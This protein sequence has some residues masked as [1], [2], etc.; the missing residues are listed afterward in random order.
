MKQRR[1]FGQASDRV[2]YPWMGPQNGKPG[3]DCAVL[4]CSGKLNLAS[5]CEACA[6]RAFPPTARRL[7]GPVWFETVEDL[8]R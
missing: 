4:N 6:L 8:T 2:G 3:D 1:R 5:I 7:E